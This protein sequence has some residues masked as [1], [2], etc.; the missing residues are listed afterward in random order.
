[1]TSQPPG[2]AW[3]IYFRLAGVFVFMV[4]AAVLGYGVGRL[5]GDPASTAELAEVL[6]EAE[7]AR[8]G[9]TGTQAPP[10][11]FFAKG[12]ISEAPETVLDQIG[13]AARAG[14]HRHVLTLRLSWDDPPTYRDATD[15]L[16]RILEV[17][18]AAS[19]VLNLDLNPPLAWLTE[20]PTEA[21]P[22]SATADATVCVA[23][24][25]W[26]HQAGERIAALFKALYAARLQDRIAGVM[27]SALGDGA[28]Y[29][30]LEG[31]APADTEAFRAWL[32]ARYETDAGL[33][34]AWRVPDAFLAKA[35]I[36]EAVITTDET[37]VFFDETEHARVDYLRYA[38]DSV[39]DAITTM[40][41]A[42]KD[43][44]GPRVEV[45]VPYGHSFEILSNA[46]GHLALGKVLDGPVDGLVSPVS[47]YERGLGGAGGF[48]GPITSAVAHHVQWYV[49]D[50]A[51]TGIQRD[52]L[53]GELTALG[54]GMVQDVQ[55]IHKRNFAYAYAY[56]LGLM[57]TDP[58]SDGGLYDRRIWGYL[59]KMRD[60]YAARATTSQTTPLV[61]YSPEL[62]SRTPLAIVVDEESR[63]WQRRDTELNRL[64][65]RESVNHAMQTGVP[66][67]FVLLD[68][69]LEERVKPASVYVFLNA[70]RLEPA[71]RERLHTLLD[72]FNSAAIWLYAP[73]YLDGRG[74]SADNVSATTRIRVRQFEEP[75]RAGSLL[76]ITPPNWSVNEAP[77]GE[78]T[79]WDPLFY[80]DDPYADVLAVYTDN[81]EP[82]VA[83]ATFE[84]GWTSILVAE[85]ELPALLLSVLLD[86]LEAHLFVE[87][88]EATAG[89]VVIVGPNFLGLH[90]AGN[91]EKS[92][93]LPWPCDV[94]DKLNGESLWQ[95]RQTF[96]LPMRTGD[97]RLFELQPLR[98]R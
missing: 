54:G 78:P 12:P 58:E 20:H 80:I 74:A 8:E 95:Q 53:S 97:T 67:E 36:P 3:D 29:R 91:S 22:S 65:L 55:S 88:T 68:D 69:V 48:M 5:V 96:S 34:R 87:T 61:G 90:A 59:S 17:D 7:R 86:V 93:R 10:V 37:H 83:M 82:S 63:L 75:T 66:C 46:S 1:M 31:T 41:E 44:A 51:R 62:S 85:P 16:H 21:Y 28:W 14:V 72:R 71:R 4:V 27:L 30:P 47:Y 42:V 38:S 43:A 11:F 35:V 18:A 64:L 45:L 6:E 24:E 2:K 89:D 60:A 84:E 79:V 76:Q 13:L 70:F 94:L 77:F 50:D 23:S 15:L 25:E 19:L 92:V 49:V 40:A 33:Q 39:A 98:G 81:D 32:S 56:G 73:G 57:W 52:P 9:T 26:Q